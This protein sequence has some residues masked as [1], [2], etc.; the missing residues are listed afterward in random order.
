LPSGPLIC[1]PVPPV[2]VNTRT[3]GP[4]PAFAP[5]INSFFPPRMMSPVA[6]KT[7]P[8]KPAS[9]A[10]KLAPSWGVPALTESPSKTLTCGGPAR[11]EGGGAAGGAAAGRAAGAHQAPPAIAGERDEAGHLQ[12]GQDAVDDDVPADLGADR[13]QR[14]AAQHVAALQPLQARP[15]RPPAGRPPRGGAPPAADTSCDRHDGFLTRCSRGSPRGPAAV[16]ALSTL[17]KEH[18][19]GAPS[20]NP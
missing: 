1:W 12:A 5:T 19:S 13:E 6:T 14:Q 8:V 18:P 16:R 4:A 10:R 9:K 17:L 11:P 15:V 7:P 20:S 3:L 2:T